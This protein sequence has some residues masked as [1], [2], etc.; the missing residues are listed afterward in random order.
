MKKLFS[1]LLIVALLPC[2]ALAELNFGTLLNIAHAILTTDFPAPTPEPSPTPVAEKDLLK[3]P[4]DISGEVLRK[5][6]EEFDY[7]S[8]MNSP[9]L[10]KDTSVC[11]S[12]WVFMKNIFDDGWAYA[13]IFDKDSRVVYILLSPESY[14]ESDLEI[15]N[16]IEVFGVTNGKTNT[17]P[18]YPIV[19]AS[20]RIVN[21]GEK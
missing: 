8:A 18:E 4:A 3:N 9:S 1:A 21:H 11:V 6:Y 5:M 19:V 15:G 7:D 20:L 2:V 10:Y 14:V 13:L 17:K 16:V 12:G